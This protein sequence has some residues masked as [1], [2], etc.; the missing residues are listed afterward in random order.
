[1]PSNFKHSLCDSV[2]CELSSSSFP[3]FSHRKAG[4]QFSPL[5]FELPIR[6]SST[7]YDKVSSERSFK[8]SIS[9]RFT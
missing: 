9:Y 7:L 5:L 2:Y 1:M 4:P 8:F 3:P 6:G